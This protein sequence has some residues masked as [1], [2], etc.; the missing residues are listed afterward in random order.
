MINGFNERTVS[1]CGRAPCLQAG[2]FQEAARAP[3]ILAKNPCFL[4]QAGQTLL[5][6]PVATTL[7]NAVRSLNSSDEIIRPISTALML[8]MKAAASARRN[9]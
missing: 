2:T 5:A 8:M 6:R 4:T 3:W 9:S 1:R 7:V